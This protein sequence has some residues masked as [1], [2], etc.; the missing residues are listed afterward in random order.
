MV[1]EIGVFIIVL[2]VVFGLFI[3]LHPQMYT[4]HFGQF[5]KDKRWSD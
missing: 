2:G 4:L 1:G 5:D 3:R